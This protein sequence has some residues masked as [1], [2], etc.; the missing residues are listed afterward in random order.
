MF[1]K[2][3]YWLNYQYLVCELQGVCLLY[4]ANLIILSKEYILTLAYFGPIFPGNDQVMMSQHH[5]L[6]ALYVSQTPIPEDSYR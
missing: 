6:V 3:L 4:Q 2:W 5:R 1:S